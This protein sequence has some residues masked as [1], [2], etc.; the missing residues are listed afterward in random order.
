VPRELDAPG[1]QQ[2]IYT[3]PVKRRA[4]RIGVQRLAPLAV[5]FLMAF[6]AILG[7]GKSRGRYEVVALDGGVSRRGDLVFAEME[8][9][10]FPNVFCVLLTLGA[11][12]RGD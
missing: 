10:V 9:I 4:K 6:T 3:G 8:T 11:D 2:D 7:F 12:L 1:A 5:S